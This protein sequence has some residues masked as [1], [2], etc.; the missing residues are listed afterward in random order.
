MTGQEII[1]AA[2]RQTGEFIDTPEGL[3]CINEALDRIGDM[4][5]VYD[6]C[7]IV[8]ELPGIPYDLPPDMTRVTSV[9]D[10]RGQVCDAYRVEGNQ[11][12]F[13]HPGSYT[14][15]Y[16]RLP[17]HLSVL[18]EIPEVHLSQHGNLITYVKAW[19]LLREDDESPRGLQLEQKFDQDVQRTFLLQLRNKRYSDVIPVRA[20]VIG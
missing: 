9:L 6:S 13:G 17:R 10:A 5:L 4:A 18:T 19:M 3:T 12:S 16:R 14:V 2:M 15:R 20:A 7:T 11:I 1:E 8:A